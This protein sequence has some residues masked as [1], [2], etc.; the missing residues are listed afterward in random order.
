MHETMF[1]VFILEVNNVVA[2][3]RQQWISKPVYLMQIKKRYLGSTM[4]K[5]INLLSMTRD[6]TVS[7]RDVGKKSV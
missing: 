3:L 6:A 4:Q 7:G 5:S 2:G 1:N